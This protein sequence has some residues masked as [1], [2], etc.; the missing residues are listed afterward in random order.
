MRSSSFKSAQ[1]HGRAV[2]WIALAQLL[3][4]LLWIAPLFIPLSA[5]VRVLWGLLFG[6]FA[7]LPLRF[8]AACQMRSALGEKNLL[9]ASY[10][11][12][13][14]GGALRFLLGGIWSIPL[15]GMAYLFYRYVF[16]LD[17]SRYAR[18]A[19]RLGSYFAAGAG[20]AQQQMI[21]LVL[22]GIACLISFSLYF[23]GW[24]RHILYEFLLIEDAAAIPTLSTAR[25]MKKACRRDL[26]ILMAGNLLTLLPALL[27]PPA[28][29]C[30]RC[31]GVQNML[32][33]LFLL[34]SNGMALDPAS[35]WLTLALFI[36][37]Y[38]PLIPYRK[39]RYAALVNRNEG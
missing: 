16:V 38:F 20:E 9:P 26:L 22:V 37:L 5:L 30:W 24:R 19:A 6:L 32:M 12:R 39:R 25:T 13:L 29:L 10:V 31:G 7:V 34:I 28:F 1:K 11:C 14:G 21:G 35:L 15:I 33:S 36:L 3:V 23:Y 8:R 18:D 4:R 17:A 27:L 2:C